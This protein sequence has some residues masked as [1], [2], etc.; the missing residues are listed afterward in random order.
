MKKSIF[1]IILF[2][3]FAL[4]VS[5]GAFSQMQSPKEFFGFEPGADRMLITY[6]QLIDYL[7][8]ADGTSPMLKLEKIGESSE[9][10]P[11][12]IA[13]I[14]SPENI[15]RLDE[16]KEINRQ[17]ALDAELTEAE[18]EDLVE[19]GRV[20]FLATLSMHSTE[21]GPS[22]AAPSIAY[23]LIMDELTLQDSAGRSL[24]QP[25][26]TRD[27]HQAQN[28]KLKIQNFLQDVVYMMVPCHNPDGMDMVVEHYLKHK[29]TRYEGTNVPGLYQKY[30]GHDNN[31]DFVILSQPETRAVAAIYNREW[32]PQ[33]MI[34]KHQMGSTGV[35]YFV[36]PPHDPI[37]ENV[38]AEL[39]SWI[40]LFG[41]NMMKDM[42]ARGQKGIAQR[43]L[44]DDYW[45]GSTETCIW[46]NVIG[47][48]TEAASVRV[49]TPIYIE[50]NE[51]QARGK[52][53]SEYKKSINM[54]EPW[55]GGWWRLGDI[56]DYEKAS[57]W[58]IIKTASAHKEEILRF[59]NDLC[60]KEVEKGRTEAPF[61]YVIPR[62][63]DDPGEMVRL[64]N[65]LREHGVDV[66][67]LAG[68]MQIGDVRYA[69]GDIVVPLDQPF[70]A[71]I[72]E[73]MEEQVF[74][75]R[76]YTPDGEIIRPYD[77][78][79]WSLPL[80]NGVKA[81]EITT[82]VP[83]IRERSALIT[84]DLTLKE[85]LISEF[86]GM[87]FDVRM[88]ESYKAAFLAAELGLQVERLTADL[89]HN[90]QALGQG[91]FIVFGGGR[92]EPWEQL[93]EQ[94]TV[95][96]VWMMDRPEYAS[97]PFKVPRLALVETWMHDMDAGWT[98]FV[99]DQYHIPYTVIRPEDLR[100][101]GLKGKFDVVVIPSVSKDILKEGKYKSEDDYY[102]SNYH[103]DFTKGM[104]TEGLEKLMGF[105]EEGGVVVS[106]GRSTGLFDGTLKI[107]R[108]EEETEEFQLPYDDISDRLKGLY[109][110]GSFVAVELAADHPL[111]QGMPAAT[112]VFYRG[113]PV[114]TTS[115][116][117]FDMDR[118]VIGKFPEKDILLSGY[119]EK[120]EFLSDK[121]NMLWLKKGKGQM[122]LFAFNPQFRASTAANYKLLFNALLM[123]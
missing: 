62:D 89:D 81:D 103:P 31:R 13:F 76:H 37:A 6:E 23:G 98:R 15:A 115:I 83:G 52:G 21:V 60:R 92:Q 29:G 36:P 108:S 79:S 121:S 73:V 59:R 48:L 30:T 90:G 71:F 5:P 123:K 19:R 50:S 27:E 84:A 99:F 63:Q 45:P 117:N 38:D 122:V 113:S 91:S 35:R 10:R 16:L 32:F 7:K 68:D 120:E 39:W 24:V 78:A 114:F 66:Y 80:H 67:R 107:K 42:T 9:G 85:G 116:P 25:E 97:E 12:Y 3:L 22:Q 111:T 55:P 100:K 72:K 1:H 44:F 77:I 110:P 88:N 65:L 11:M 75:L 56:V 69:A 43:Y 41:S 49:A 26:W 20:F 118:R 101:T 57:T 86:W 53:L 74:P 28:S 58:S 105:V 87:A 61:F 95:D 18:R 54:P 33:V 109:C 104:G 119:I 17:L 70:R 8:M 82:F 93:Y 106:W 4:H 64:V 47:M 14:S 102:I 46:K 94:L 96:P 51:L 40:G 34:E 2:S 112:G